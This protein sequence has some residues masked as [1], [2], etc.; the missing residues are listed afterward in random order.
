MRIGK[1]V[2]FK[3][4]QTL[5]LNGTAMGKDCVVKV[6]VNFSARFPQIGLNF[7]LFVCSIHHFFLM[8]LS[9]VGGNFVDVWRKWVGT[10]WKIFNGTASM[11]CKPNNLLP[12]KGAN[13]GC[14][15]SSASRYQLSRDCNLWWESKR[16][17]NGF[18]LFPRAAASYLTA[19]IEG[20]FF[21]AD[22]SKKSFRSSQT[23]AIATN[24]N[25]N[26]WII[27]NSV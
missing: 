4:S 27:Y 8:F 13:Y 15:N 24:E 21:I 26:N 10:F 11:L 12:T 6:P 3:L 23:Q 22:H 20:L 5:P 2:Q 25:F 18:F 19:E 17:F 16:F 1:I 9:A 14:E 7:P